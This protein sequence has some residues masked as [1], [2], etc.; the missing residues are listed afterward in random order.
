M[1]V[2]VLLPE[3][4]IDSER[5]EILTDRAVIVDG[6]RIADVVRPAD[7]PSDARRIELSGHT[8]LAGLSDMPSAT[9]ISGLISI[10]G[11]T[12]F[13]SCRMIRR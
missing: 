1:S 9:V 5:G 3:R 13:A 6:E 12:R 4:V 7:V 10:S 8:L 11:A 2:T